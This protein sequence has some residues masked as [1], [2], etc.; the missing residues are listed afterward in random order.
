MNGAVP[1][2]HQTFLPHGE[3]QIHFCDHIIKE[4]EIRGACSTQRG[5]EIHGSGKRPLG[6]IKRRSV[7]NINVGLNK[8][9]RR[10]RVWIQEI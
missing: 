2:L 3:G 7:D 4:N 1:P 10:G 9:E 6:R 5:T 8:R